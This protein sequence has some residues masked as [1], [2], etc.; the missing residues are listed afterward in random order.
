M[1]PDSEILILRAEKVAEQLVQQIKLGGASSTSWMPRA[2]AMRQPDQYDLGLAT[3]ASAVPLFLLELYQITQKPDYLDTAQVLTQTILETLPAQRSF[4]FGC[5]SGKGGVLFLLLRLYEVTGSMDFLAQAQ[6]L[7]KESQAFVHSKYV[8]SGLLDGLAGLVSQLMRLYH[9][10]Q[11]QE[12]FNL[13]ED[14]L[15]QLLLPMYMTSTGVC[16]QVDY[17]RV[18]PLCG[19]GDGAAG[20]VL[21]LQQASSY[22]ATSIYDILIRWGLAYE[23][24]QWNEK[25]NNWPDYYKSIR[26][27]EDDQ[28]YTQSYQKGSRY[29]LYQPTDNLGYRHGTLGMAIHYLLLQQKLESE[30]YQEDLEKALQKITTADWAAPH[31]NHTDLC[32]LFFLYRSEGLRAKFPASIEAQLQT[33]MEQFS[34]ALSNS[35]GIGIEKGL[36]GLGYFYLLAAG[37]IKRPYFLVG[38]DSADIQALN[39]VKF[40]HSFDQKFLITEV[41][42]RN[43]ARTLA[44]LRFYFEAE[45]PKVLALGGERNPYEGFNEKLQE[46]MSVKETHP[47]LPL[48]Q[49]I[50][51]LEKQAFT[52]F[53]QN[54]SFT[55]MY[56]EHLLNYQKAEEL[57]KQGDEQVLQANCQLK[58]YVQVVET[59]WSWQA[60]FKDGVPMF[61]KN[62]EMEPGE[63]CY[64]LRPDYAAPGYKELYLDRLDFLLVNFDEPINGQ[65]IMDSLVEN[66]EIQSPG[67]L[68]ELRLQVV[69]L[70]I[71]A[72]QNGFLEIV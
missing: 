36:S 31:W 57:L 35:E 53:M 64:L 47:H 48:L 54:R 59:Q 45:L 33:I 38:L 67:S 61:L 16:W 10:T 3:G 23:K 46:L 43:F 25:I 28:R 71:T 1:K 12:V 8:D 29:L 56:I 34:L 39:E 9:Y 15:R 27:A 40:E 21:T 62:H 20:I 4:H 42:S 18:R 30:I 58:P 19:M 60:V 11:K 50:F 22:L 72:L 65:D 5:W 32:A 68:E 44:V 63:H 66:S 14:T 70:I 69:K 7:V 37:S 17:N 26:T 24:E 2:A 51:L 52:V 13:L 6:E 41:L 49:D 55:E